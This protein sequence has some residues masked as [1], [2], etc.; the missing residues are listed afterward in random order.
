MS[1][2]SK[3][4]H[5]DINRFS[6][7]LKQ[8]GYQ[9]DY[10]RNRVSYKKYHVNSNYFNHIDCEDKAYWFGFL[11]AD[12][13]NSNMY[14]QLTISKQDINHMRK[15][16]KS[17]NS[18]HP[19]LHR[20]IDNTVNVTI[21]D[22]QLTNDLRELGCVR[23]KTYVDAFP[24][25]ENIPRYFMKDF[26]RGYFDGDGCIQQMIISKKQHYKSAKRQINK[27]SFTIHSKNFSIGLIELI[28]KLCNVEAKLYYDSKYN[29]YEV[30]INGQE[31]IRRF[32]DYLYKESTIYLDR[33]YAQYL[34]YV[35][36][37]DLEIDQI[38]SAKLSGNV[39][40]D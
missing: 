22:K 30:Y 29:R 17:L 15:Y 6:K 19:I 39:L 26:I 37:F 4:L 11:M 24:S 5:I 34:Y 8:E 28:K 33:K 20:K 21:S 36:P 27:I 31:K 2:I 25:L 16:N 35:L 1:Q 18:N 13:Y 3:E 12:G 32:L 7:L 40:P 10:N 9:I 38:I 23:N 14:I